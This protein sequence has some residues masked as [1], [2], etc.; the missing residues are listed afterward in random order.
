MDNVTK[1]K[2]PNYNNTDYPLAVKNQILNYDTDQKNLDSE[3]LR[4]HQFIP[5]EFFTKNPSSRGLLLVHAMGMGKTRLAVSIADYYSNNDPSRNIIILLPKSLE[6]NFKSS[7]EEFAR[8]VDGD[9][10]ADVKADGSVLLTDKYKYV[11]LN[12][13]NMYGKMKNIDKSSKEVAYEKKLGK[14]MEDIDRKN[15]LNNSL[16]IIDEAHNLF[17][18][19][20]NGSKNAVGLY[21]LIIRAKNLKLLFLTGTPII[22]NPFELTACF[23]MLRGPMM[24]LGNK[25][26][27]KHN[28]VFTEDYQE[29][30]DYFIDTD[31]N[32]LKNRSKFKN[33]IFGLT[34]YY[35]D[36]YFAATTQREGFPTQLTTIIEKVPMSV[37]QYER[38]AIVRTL[39]IE[40]DSKSKS[41]RGMDTR[42]SSSA[43]SSG[44]YRVGSR[45][46][47]NYA[48]PEYALGPVMAKKARAKYIEKINDE[49]LLDTAKYSPKFGRIIDNIEKNNN[50]GI[51]YSQFVSGEGLGILG[52]ILEQKNWRLYVPPSYQDDIGIVLNSD[53]ADVI[54]DSIDDIDDK[55]DKDD[56]SVVDIDD[57]SVVGGKAIAKPK[58]NA[59]AKAK[60][61]NPKAKA[62]A[63]KPIKAK[64]K[65][66]P[67]KAIS[68]Y[69]ILS[70]AVNI[71]DRTSI[72]N[73]FNSKENANG[74]IIKI[75]LL[76]SAV[77]EGIDL[78]RVRHV[79][80]MEPFWNYARIKQVETRANRYLSHIDLNKK[81]QN[82]QT[83][84]YL[85]TYPLTVTKKDIPTTDI[86]LYIKAVNGMKLNDSFLL[87]LAESSI[88][89]TR[90]KQD[91]PE[92][93]QKLINCTICSPT[94]E[95]LYNP[96]ISKDM[97]SSNACTAYSE[98]K[99]TVEEIAL[100]DSDDKYY[101]TTNDDNVV[102][103]LYD[104]KIQGYI[105]MPREHM[106]YGKLMS[107]ILSEMYK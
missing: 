95:P 21:D 77:A 42:F 28:L 67:N 65:P 103:Y 39:E 91:L 81:D 70:G 93:L 57:T 25:S 45:Q 98:E 62:K 106:N 10:K 107:K 16:L 68:Y 86:D 32:R 29:F 41:F 99:V 31:K 79:H 97:I 34:S 50:L 74:E 13:G 27:R 26:S 90:H 85:S 6:S 66:K 92:K 23:N 33:R 44:T 14:F 35:S 3:Q 80:I 48:I 72:I 78:K 54:A 17:N 30:K 11:S 46:V 36:I 73:T 102:L 69:A 61:V 55:D 37:Y 76:S 96:I 75:L 15:S 100:S 60:A 94:N 84:I 8:Q 101:Y 40:E 88:D 18:G 82:V 83:Y 38:Y 52:R 2:L 89:C 4:L 12:A 59:K 49:D 53:L 1:Y 56:T 51:V 7:A 104:D 20:T 19:I 87:A 43:G 71:D 63:V 24:P 105:E 58:A 64:A 9:V 47:S 5:K 22:N